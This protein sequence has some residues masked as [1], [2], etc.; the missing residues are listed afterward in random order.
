MIR[1]WTYLILGADNED[2]AAALAEAI[3][4]NAPPGTSVQVTDNAAV[5]CDFSKPAAAEAATL[6]LTL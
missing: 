3:G 6:F 5:S 2:Q 1:R 4:Q